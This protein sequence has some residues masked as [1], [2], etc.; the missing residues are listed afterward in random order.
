[1]LHT[2]A[3]VTTLYNLVPVGQKPVVLCSWAAKPCAW[4][5]IMAAYAR[6]WVWD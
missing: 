4:Q 2:R 1:M 5:K 3:S 6:N